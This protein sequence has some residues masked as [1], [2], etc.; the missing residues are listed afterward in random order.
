MY[1]TAWD[2]NVEG[3][4]YFESSLLQPFCKWDTTVKVQAHNGDIGSFGL[5]DIF[6]LG[7]R[8]AQGDYVYAYRTEDKAYAT[9]GR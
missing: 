7:I 2:E 5:D 3:G 1:F 6:K 8:P 4:R 9:L